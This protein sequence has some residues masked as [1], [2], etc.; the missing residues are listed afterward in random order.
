MLKVTIIALGHLKE[1]YLREAS[2]EYEKRLKGFCKL[3]I[4]ELEP[5]RLSDNPKQSEIDNALNTEA[6][7]II[8]LVPSNSFL[9][10][11]CIEGKL[12][13]SE[14]LSK[15]I[16]TIAV[17]GSSHLVFVIGSSYGLSDRIK[18]QANLKMSM[19]PMTFPHQLARIMLL[20][21]IY[22][23]FKISQGGTYHK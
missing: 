2:A 8:S 3:E 4:I 9:I 18:S 10:P 22:R 7:K 23:A 13:S 6:E 11:L 21:Q 14:E 5:V 12:I 1:K 20:E 17:S 19:S 15:K 16:E